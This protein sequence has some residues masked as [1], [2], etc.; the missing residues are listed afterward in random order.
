[1]TF[2]LSSLFVD[3]EQTID[4]IPFGEYDSRVIF[5]DGVFINGESV[6][7]IS[8]T[9]SEYVVQ[10]DGLGSILINV[11]HGD[12]LLYGK[13][14]YLVLNEGEVF[15]HP[16]TGRIALEFR[17]TIQFTSPPY[18]LPGVR[19]G[20]YTV[21]LMSPQPSPDSSYGL[22]ETHVVEGAV[23]DVVFQLDD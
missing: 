10:T 12:G 21:V 15:R 1:M 11:Q 2:K 8:D 23:A 17:S 5:Q 19:P 3:G 13:S 4:A 16:K 6:V 9:Q 20:M 14:I 7:T 22:M 18:L